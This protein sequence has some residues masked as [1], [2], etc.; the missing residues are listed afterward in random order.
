[1][2]K[3]TGIYFYGLLIVA[4]AYSPKFLEQVNELIMISEAVRNQ[5]K[6]LVKK[7]YAACG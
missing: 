6:I 1:M 7:V 3:I 2:I 4:S 5:N